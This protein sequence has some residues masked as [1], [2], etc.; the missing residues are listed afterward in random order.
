M[1]MCLSAIRPVRAPIPAHPCLPTTIR[2]VCFQALIYN[3]SVLE[4]QPDGTLVLM[5]RLWAAA[6]PV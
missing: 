4:P 2:L 3:Q 6:T 5:V 1:L